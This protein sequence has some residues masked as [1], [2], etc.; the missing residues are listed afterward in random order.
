MLEKA[1]L[2]IGAIGGIA[3]IVALALVPDLWGRVY[4]LPLLI[5]AVII[6]LLLAGMLVRRSSLTPASADQDRLDQLFQTLP[7]DSIR[8]LQEEDFG[9]PWR[10]EIFDPVRRFHRNLAE[11]EHELDRRDL[12]DHRRI[13]LDAAGRLLDAEGANGFT[14]SE[15]PRRYTGFR[16][17][18]LE[19]AG[20][21]E[22]RE[23]NRRRSAI[24]EARDA[25]VDAHED[26]VRRAKRDGF[27]LAALTLHLRPESPPTLDRG[28]PSAVRA[29]WPGEP[30]R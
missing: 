28:G 22:R 6:C 8:S 18:D 12:E 30:T 19:T 20:P 10:S 7:R 9:L 1:A 23:F 3:S 13:L 5:V 26:L 11:V 17:G 2:W 27:D 24:Q 25:F 4:P 29:H 21:D 16:P 14:M 15:L